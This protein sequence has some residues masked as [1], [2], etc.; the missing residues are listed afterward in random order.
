M[1]FGQ[2][3]TQL[4]ELCQAEGFVKYT[5]RQLCDWMYNKRV[6]DIDLMTNLSLKVRARLKEIERVGRELPTDCQESR[7]GTRKYLFRVGEEKAVEAVFIP[8]DE[9]ATLC[10]S[11]QVGCKMGCRFCVTGQQG[12]YGSLTTGEILN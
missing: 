10:V 9:R 7:D 4:Q 12:Y 5:A 2:T 3:L 6:N 11:C 8:A 1:L